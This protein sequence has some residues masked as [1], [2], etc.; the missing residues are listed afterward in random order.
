MRGWGGQGTD[1]ALDI[2]ITRTF[3]CECITAGEL[4]FQDI[5]R[6]NTWI[7]YEATSSLVETNPRGFSYTINHTLKEP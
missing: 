4:T 6:T 3:F 2:P 5:G 7:P 1:G